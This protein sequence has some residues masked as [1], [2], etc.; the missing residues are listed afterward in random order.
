MITRRSYAVEPWTVRETDLGLD[1]PAQSESAFAL[2]NG[3]IGRRGNL[4]E[5]EPPRLPGAYLNGVHELRPLPYAEA[6]YGYPE[7]G[8][9]VIDVTNG[10]VARRPARPTPTGPPGSRTA[11]GPQAQLTLSD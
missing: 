7:P 3:H 11:P 10:K 4:G 8:Q 2:S 5:G 1:V 6:G 9:T